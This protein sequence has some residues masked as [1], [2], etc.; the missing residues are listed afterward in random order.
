MNRYI[1]GF[2]LSRDMWLAGIWNSQPS[3]SLDLTVR[4]SK[5]EAATRFLP[6]LLGGSLIPIVVDRDGDGF[7]MAKHYPL[8]EQFVHLSIFFVAN[9]ANPAL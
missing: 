5:L 8:T 9:T 4:R 6:I 3:P 2:P 1:L 7:S